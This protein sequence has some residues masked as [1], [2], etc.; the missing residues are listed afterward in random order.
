MLEKNAKMGLNTV[1]FL[2]DHLWADICT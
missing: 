2:S 1:W